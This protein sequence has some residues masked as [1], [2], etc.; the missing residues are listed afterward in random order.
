MMELEW[1]KTSQCE[2]RQNFPKRHVGNLL[3]PELSFE[4]L[5]RIQSPYES[6]IDRGRHIH[7]G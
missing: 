5:L 6:L 2:H 4:L 7:L 1:I 3:S